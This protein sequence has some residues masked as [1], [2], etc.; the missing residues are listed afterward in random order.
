MIED[1]FLSQIAENN[2]KRMLLQ[3]DGAPCHTA[4]EIM[5][6]LRRLSPNRLILKNGDYDWPPR[7][8]DLTPADFFLW[9]Y[10]KSKVYVSAPRSLQELK[11]AI[12]KEITEIMLETLQKV[13]E[14]AQKRAFLC[15]V[16]KGNHFPDVVF[17][18]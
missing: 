17:K 9:G 1:W 2:S 4:R 11:D 7:S 14:N 18:K 8:P 15:I 13:M 6:L 16:H 12:R 10:L 3:Q 5:I